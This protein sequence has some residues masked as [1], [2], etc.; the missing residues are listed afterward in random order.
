MASRVFFAIALI[1]AVLAGAS[2]P[3]AEPT[4]MVLEQ[5]AIHERQRIKQGDIHYHVEPLHAAPRHDMLTT[6]DM[7]LIFREGAARLD[8]SL[9][10]LNTRGQPATSHLAMFDGKSYIAF[11]DR[12][13][14]DGRQISITIGDMKQIGYGG[15]NMFDPLSIGMYPGPFSPIFKIN[16]D[17]TCSGRKDETVTRE[18][19][20]D[21]DVFHVQWTRT[22]GPECQFWI[23][24]EE[25][26]SVV[27]AKDSFLAGA[28]RIVDTNEIAVSR[29]GDGDA[30]VW[31]PKQIIWERVVDD[32]VVPSNVLTVTEAT[33][34]EPVD[35]Q[36]FELAGM[37]PNPGQS[38][39]N[40]LTPGK[41]E[42]W[43]GEKIVPVQSQLSSAAKSGKEGLSWG[44][45]AV[46]IAAG[47][48]AAV[49]FWRY[50]RGSRAR[51]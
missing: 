20:A 51:A 14:Q 47:V 37:N 39:D 27:R 33:L 35:D 43:D 29:Y 12:L 25:G 9:A 24:P 48:A 50:Y 19:L 45:L 10:G 38:I 49:V 4:A 28:K 7:R 36:L 40:Y 16:A 8:L 22:D 1:A 23:S 42:I 46:S 5:R 44:W 26:F 11:E 30:A 3:A 6:G 32:K 2:A 31:Y 13:V 21:K 34:N 17:L 41:R 15:S 18:R